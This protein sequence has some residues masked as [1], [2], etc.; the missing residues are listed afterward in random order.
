MINVNF[1]LLTSS[2]LS[3]L[4]IPIFFKGPFKKGANSLGKFIGHIGKTGAGDILGKEMNK[5][6]YEF[7]NETGN[8]I[9]LG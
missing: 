7:I 2:F 4:S 9:K 5:D 1:I 3:L 6:L 8:G